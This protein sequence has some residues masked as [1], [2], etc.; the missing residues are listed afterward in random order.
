MRAFAVL[1]GFL[2]LALPAAGQGIVQR[3]GYVRR[4][5]TYVAPSYQTAPNGTTT[6]NWSTRGNTNPFTGQPGT[7]NPS[8]NSSGSGGFGGSMYGNGPSSMYG[9]TPSSPRY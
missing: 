9:R 2:V 6:D 5:G 7:V 1:A 8:P 3:D 4:D